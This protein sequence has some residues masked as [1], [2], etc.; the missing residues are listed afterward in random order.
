MT[1]ALRCSDD[2]QLLPPGMTGAGLAALAAALM[3]ALMNRQRGS[4]AEMARHWS[5]CS[6]HFLEAA[7][8]LPSARN[9]MALPRMRL[10]GVALEYRLKAFLCV[11]RGGA[12]ESRDL[13]RLAMLAT[14]CGLSLTTRQFESIAALDHAHVAKVEA[15][16]LPRSEVIRELC[17]SISAQA[18]RQP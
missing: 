9:E 8:H 5:S 6:D 4:A 17:S 16:D 7:E 2:H 1:G 12:P 11:A 3:I 18:F 10:L 13:S 14:H 15:C